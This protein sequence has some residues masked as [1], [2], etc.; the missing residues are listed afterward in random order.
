[1]FSER[2]NKPTNYYTRSPPKKSKTSSLN[3]LQKERNEKGRWINLYTYIELCRISH[4]PSYFFCSLLIFRFLQFNSFHPNVHFTFYLSI[5]LFLTLLI[6]LSRSLSLSLFAINFTLASFLF[7]A[8]QLFLWLLICFPLT[9]N[10]NPII[11][12][13]VFSSEDP[14]S[15][16]LKVE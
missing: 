1:M 13:L 16:P 3:F 4:G 12:S 9:G 6:S 7:H 5:Y 10:V 14:D 11:A 8:I 2:A 15:R